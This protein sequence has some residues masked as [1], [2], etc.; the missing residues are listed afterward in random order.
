MKELW[1]RFLCTDIMMGWHDI[2]C[3]FRKWLNLFMK[4]PLGYRGFSHDFFGELVS[5]VQLYCDYDYYWDY[6]ND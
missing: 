4:S 1:I 5:T 3:L 6:Y 2:G